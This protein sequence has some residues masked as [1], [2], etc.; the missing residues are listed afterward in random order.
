MRRDAQALFDAALPAARRADLAARGRVGDPGL[1]CGA[2]A[3]AWSAKRRAH[4]HAPGR[5]TARARSPAGPRWRLAVARGELT[6]E[7]ALLPHAL[8]VA[9]RGLAT[10]G[11]RRLGLE[12]LDWLIAVQTTRRGTFTPIGNDGW[13]TREAVPAASSTSNP[14]R[15]PR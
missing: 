11:L 13:W 1:R 15:R 9:G 8:I 7:N 6:Y 3:A 5:P 4:L 10:S 2:R 12:V 14:S